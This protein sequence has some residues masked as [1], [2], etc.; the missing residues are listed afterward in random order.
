MTSNRHDLR[1]GQLV[2]KYVSKLVAWAVIGSPVMVR[3][4]P[5][6]SSALQS[7]L[8]NDGASH[9]M[10]Y[11]TVYQAWDIV[12]EGAYETRRLLSH[13]GGGFDDSA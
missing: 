10:L 6:D 3:T 11:S 13:L 12:A 9:V 4:S 8:R 1:L 2:D 7:E 5:M